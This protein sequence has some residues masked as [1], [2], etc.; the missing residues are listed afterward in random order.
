MMA[1][2]GTEGELESPEEAG[3]SKPPYLSS[4]LTV[5]LI[6]LVAICMMITLRDEGRIT[7]LEDQNKMKAQ[8]METIRSNMLVLT[9]RDKDRAVEYGKVLS[10]IEGLGGKFDRLHNDIETVKKASP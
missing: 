7:R 4:Y 2:M 5:I 10:G 3:T 1:I 8:E 9:D 6:A